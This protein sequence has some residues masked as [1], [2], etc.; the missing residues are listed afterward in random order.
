MPNELN[1]CTK[2]VNPLETET[3]VGGEGTGTTSS[4]P[5]ISGQHGVAERAKYETPKD[6]DRI[7]SSVTHRL[8]NLETSHLTS[9]NLSLSIYKIVLLSVRAFVS[10]CFALY[11]TRHVA[12]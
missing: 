9:L 10:V 3:L 5:G 12:A 6:V 2:K 7:D 1:S 11:T 4:F 8:C